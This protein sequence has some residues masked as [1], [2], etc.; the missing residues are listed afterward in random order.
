[1]LRSHKAQL[2][3]S[4]LKFDGIRPIEILTNQERIQTMIFRLFRP[5]TTV[6]LGSSQASL[7]ITTT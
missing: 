3:G 5:R 2:F 6:M 4:I 1:M 7:R